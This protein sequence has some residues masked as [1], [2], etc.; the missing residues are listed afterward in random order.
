MSGATVRGPRRGNTVPCVGARA[1]VDDA[2]EQRGASAR[3]GCRAGWRRERLGAGFSSP[4]CWPRV[5]TRRRCGQPGAESSRWWHSPTAQRRR[6]DQRED[7]TLSLRCHAT[8]AHTE[9]RC[10]ASSTNSIGEPIRS[11]SAS[12][13][14]L[15]LPLIDRCLAGWA[16]RGSPQHFETA[17]LEASLLRHGWRAERLA[18]RREVGVAFGRQPWTVTPRGVPSVPRAPPRRSASARA[19]GWTGSCWLRT[20]RRSPPAARV[21]PGAVREGR[22]VWRGFPDTQGCSFRM[23]RGRSVMCRSGPTPRH[24]IPHQWWPAARRRAKRTWPLHSGG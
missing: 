1:I 15:K 21:E 6:A 3:P 7:Q 11:D 14:F 4:S 13:D 12:C 9:G 5:G 23:D 10:P 19:D 16:R 17:D 2:S 8:P 20:A 24:C 22:S 18:R